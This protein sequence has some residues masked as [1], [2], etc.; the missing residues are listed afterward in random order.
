VYSLA[1]FLLN[2]LTGSFPI[3]LGIVLFVSVFLQTIYLQNPRMIGRAV[4]ALRN[5]FVFSQGIF[6]IG[7]VSAEAFFS[8]S[9][10]GLLVASI[11]FALGN[12]AYVKKAGKI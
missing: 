3:T 9:V 2:Y 10:L 4:M 5:S 11:V 1:G 8:N 6:G 7:G 12:V